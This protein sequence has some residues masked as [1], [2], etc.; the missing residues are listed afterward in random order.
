MYDQN[1]RKISELNN[2]VPKDEIHKY[3]K[4]HDINIL[5][6][7]REGLKIYL[8]SFLMQ[9]LNIYIKHLEYLE[10]K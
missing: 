6:L 8:Q 9:I 3:G 4:T 10:V 1:F 5:T 2:L 7:T